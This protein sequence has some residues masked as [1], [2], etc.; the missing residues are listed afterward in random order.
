VFAWFNSLLPKFAVM[1]SQRPRYCGGLVLGQTCGIITGH[2]PV[3]GELATHGAT[4]GGV[5]G[6]EAGVVYAPHEFLLVSES[7]VGEGCV[8]FVECEVGSVL[9][10][11]GEEGTVFGFL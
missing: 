7:D 3:V 2:V 8:F 6:E 4:E 1:V 5:V 9:R 11:A 10:G